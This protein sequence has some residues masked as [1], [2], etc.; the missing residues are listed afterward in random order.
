MKTTVIRQAALGWILLMIGLAPQAFAQDTDWDGDGFVGADDPDPLVSNLPG[1]FG[2]TITDADVVW[3]LDMKRL[4]DDQAVSARVRQ[5]SDTLLKTRRKEFNRNAFVGGEVASSVVAE[6]KLNLTANPFKVLNSG[7]TIETRGEVAAKAGGQLDWKWADSQQAETGTDTRKT[8]TKTVSDELRTVIRDPKLTF[9]INFLNRGDVPVEAHNLTIPVILADKV[10]GNALPTTGPFQIPAKRTRV[11][12][13]FVAPIEDTE[14]AEVIGSPG[15][16][17]KLELRPERSTGTLVL[18]KNGVETDLI[19]ELESMWDKC[20]RVSLRHPSGQELVWWVAKRQPDPDHPGADMPIRA[21]DACEAV[22]AML[23]RNLQD[24]APVW[25]MIEGRL[26]SASGWEQLG[27]EL[28]W[29][30]ISVDGKEQPAFG[31]LEIPVKESLVFEAVDLEHAKE[32]WLKTQR[33]LESPEARQWLSNHKGQLP[34]GVQAGIGRCLLEGWGVAR[35]D[36]EQAVKWVRS[37][38]ERGCPEAQY[39]I[40]LC[41]DSGI[42]VAPNPEAATN[43]LRKAADQGNAGA[44]SEMQMR[45][46]TG[47][48]QREFEI[49]S[50]V[51]MVLCW[52]PA[53]KFTMGSPVGEDGRGEDET[54]HQVTLTKAFWLGRTEVTQGQWQAVMGSSPSHFKGKDLP[55]EAVSWNDA[56]D[57]CKKLNAKGLLPTGWR[58]TLPTE[59]QWEYACRAGTTGGYA[60]TLDAMAWYY[61]NSGSK[62]HPVG[63]KQANAW[64]LADM[65]GNVWEWCADWSGDYPK[66]AVTDPA[67]PNNGSSRVARGGSWDNDGSYCRSA[68]CRRNTPDYRYNHTGFRVA[69]V[70]VGP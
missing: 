13:R 59:A 25:T 37:P 8:D 60:G 6:G 69:A 30:R 18:K 55:V 57:F 16:L 65:H 27:G 58:W 35:P 67:G 62:T 17:R 42:G 39:L 32:A 47:G 66:D 24:K 4:K 51:K 1:Q 14:F 22:N 44:K 54:P 12:V 38:A 64:G 9:T 7:G 41:Y 10:V 20:V 56:S 28:V 70:P 63:T 19:S 46:T 48:E 23:K 26:L 31:S 50:G 43:W 49:A 52:I 53:G 36:A 29:W 3:D 34:D 2:W 68:Y 5:E 21:S 45:R 61:S 11:A 40:G 15:L 33:F